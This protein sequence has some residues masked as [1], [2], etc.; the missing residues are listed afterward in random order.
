MRDLDKI[1]SVLIIT[2]AERLQQRIITKIKEIEKI[3]KNAPL[4]YVSLNKTQKSTEQVLKQEKINTKKIFFIDGVTAEKIRDDVIHV[5]PDDL[6]LLRIAIVSFIKSIKG[7][8]TLMIDALST[9]LI[10]NDE[11]EV[12]RFILGVT[13]DATQHNVQ[14]FAFSP[15]TRGEELLTK[16][17]NFFDRVQK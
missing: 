11:N 3:K 1:S 15:K 4:I 12:A 2:S 5:A 14:I 17:F 8:K 9:L 10:Y 6:T 7:E 13:E 16:I